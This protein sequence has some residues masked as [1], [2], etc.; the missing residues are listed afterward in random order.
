MRGIKVDRISVVNA[1]RKVKRDIGKVFGDDFLKVITEMILNADDSYNRMEMDARRHAKKKILI[2]L[3]RKK[4]VIEVV[5]QAE[6]M[7]FEKM[8]KIFSHYGGDYSQGYEHKMVRGLF[9]Q[10]A[11]DVMFLSAFHQFKSYMISVHNDQPS[12]CDFYFDGKRE[13]SAYPVN[14][15]VDYIRQRFG[16]IKSGTYAHFGIPE[17]VKLPKRKSIQTDIE[18]FYMLRYI[19]SNKYREVILYDDNLKHRLDSSRFTF[20]QSTIL[21]NKKRIQLRF[22]DTVLQSSLTVYKKKPKEPQKII[23]KDENNVVFDETLFGLDHMHGVSYIAGEYEIKG[24][25]DVLRNKLNQKEPEEILRDSRDGFDNRHRYV[26]YMNKRV[27]K[28]L[29]ETI[30]SY[31]LERDSVAYS[32]DEN[33]KL[34]DALKKINQYFNELQLSSIGGFNQGVDAPKE[35]L[36]FA[37]PEI[38]IT[39]DK[40][41]GLQLYI[42]SE[43]VPPNEMISLTVETAQNSIK[44]EKEAV[45]YRLD[46]INEHQL[47]IKH[48]LLRGLKITEQP[49]TL[50]AS[51][52]RL[53]TVVLINVVKEKIIYPLNGLEFVPKRKYAAPSKTT[54]LML[55]YDL[56]FIPVD[57]MINIHINY[58]SRLFPDELVLQTTIDTLVSNTIGVIKV[59]IQT[60]E[61]NDKITLK[62]S[63]NEL[64]SEAVVYVKEPKEQTEGSEGLLSKLELVYDPGDW[65]ANMIKETGTLQINGKHII[66][67]TI[68]G[69]MGQKQKQRPKFDG[70]QLKYLY[71]LIAF[72]SAKLYVLD[73]Y[74]QSDHQHFEK[75]TNEVQVHKTLVYKNLIK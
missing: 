12:R 25:S 1:S 47:V 21:L 5:D 41:Y 19:L 57:Q 14:E 50:V 26:K 65:Q 6:G 2:R 73:K 7:T 52:K 39:K 74:Q 33:K 59:P 56:N 63:Y 9:G 29:M 46:D 27:T 58:H 3:N 53:K 37:R 48:I 43:M 61:Y 10:G 11:S 72:E 66:N 69:N 40:T 17:T 38:N 34:M 13:I 16:I 71:E 42:N 35:G 20:D 22:D 51:Y 28:I 4:R 67:Q 55:W 64:V 70:K 36:R 49:I 44:I 60:S 18:S 30:D 75:L 68:M 15:D 54:H 45:K 31:N 32:L 23:I 24:I 8:A 62:A